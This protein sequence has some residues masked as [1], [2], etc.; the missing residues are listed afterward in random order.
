[1]QVR[2]QSASRY[3]HHQRTQLQ[4]T[5]C[6]FPRACLPA[7]LPV[8]L[9]VCLYVWTS[10]GL[11]VQSVCV[12][13]SECLDIRWT[14]C[15][16]CVY[17][18][19][20]LGIRRSLSLVCLCVIL[21]QTICSVCLRVVLCLSVCVL[22]CLPPCLFAYFHVQSITVSMIYVCLPVCLLI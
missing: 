17:I 7:C 6:L 11:S 12:Y 9:F 10:A 20:C 4:G 21:R 5:G 16:I 19:V 13:S 8:G 18:S 3:P 14:I 1:M 15:S 2:G 22:E